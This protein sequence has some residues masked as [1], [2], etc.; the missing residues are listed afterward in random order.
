[1]KGFVVVGV[2]VVAV[3]YCCIKGGAKEER[4]IE[5]MKWRE[6]RNAGGKH[7]QPKPN[8]G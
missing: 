8:K 7:R 5:K 4:Q 3:L 6:E 2:F 1:M